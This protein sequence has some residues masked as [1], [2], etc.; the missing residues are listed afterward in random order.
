[1]TGGLKNIK[2]KVCPKTKI[3]FYKL[4]TVPTLLYNAVMDHVKGGCK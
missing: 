1:M 4:I 3:K 2:N